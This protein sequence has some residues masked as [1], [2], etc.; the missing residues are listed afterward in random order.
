VIDQSPTGNCFA[1]RLRL[2]LAREHLDRAE[3]DDAD[4][5][6]PATWF[7]AFATA[8][9]NLDAWHAGGRRGSRP[10][11]RLRTY[12]VQPLSRRTAL[13]AHP[14]YHMIYDPDGRPPALRR[15]GAF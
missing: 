6:D 8:A 14:M 7:A 2:G 11:G 1:R 3:G 15:R 13:W 4:L 9:A 10:A 5:H 12:Q